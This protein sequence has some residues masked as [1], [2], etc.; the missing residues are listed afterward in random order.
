MWTAGIKQSESIYCIFKSAHW[1]VQLWG[2]MNERGQGWFQSGH[3]IAQIRFRH[4]QDSSVHSFVHDMQKELYCTIFERNERGR[5][6]WPRFKP[7]VTTTTAAQHSLSD[8]LACIHLLNYQHW[9]SP[10][11]T[12]VLRHILHMIYARQDNRARDVCCAF[13][14]AICQLLF[15]HYV[16]IP[17]NRHVCSQELNSASVKGLTRCT[18]L[19][20]FLVL[21]ENNNSPKNNVSS[22]EF[23]AEVTWKNKNHI[24]SS[25]TSSNVWIPICGV[26]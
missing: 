23:T 2:H 8:P 13:S 24:K 17:Q 26:D 9:L 22:E 25:R 15:I 14:Y 4:C 18:W 1:D 6:N 16:I 19:F 10:A 7:A 11:S 5:F 3:Y 20:S 12:G 21:K